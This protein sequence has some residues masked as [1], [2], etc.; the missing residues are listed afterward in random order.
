VSRKIGIEQCKK[1]AMVKG[2]RCLSTEYV[3]IFAKLCWQCEKGHEWCASLASIKYHWCPTCARERVDIAR[4]EKGIE[5]CKQYAVERGG[6]CLSP[7][8]VDIKKKLRW[9][10]AEGH[11]WVADFDHVKRGHWC[12]I[13]AKERHRL[14]CVSERSGIEQCKEYAITKGGAC[15]SVEYLNGHTKLRWQCA[16]GHEWDAPWNS[17]QRGHWCNYCN[18][19]LMEGMCR[20]IFETIYGRHFPKSRPFKRPE[21]LLELD[22][23][24]KELNLAFEYDGYQHRTG[25]IFGCQEIDSSIFERDRQKNI[26]CEERGI[27]LIRISDIETTRESVVDVIMRKLREKNISFP[28]PTEEILS[29]LRTPTDAVYRCVYDPRYLDRLREACEKHID[30]TTGYR[31]RLVDAGWAGKTHTYEIVCEK[32]HH[33]KA[34]PDGIMSKRGRWCPTCGRERIIAANEP[35]KVGIERCKQYA[36]DK[37][38]ACLSTDYVNCRTKLHWR[39]MNGHEWYAV[40]TCVQSG[41]WCQ[42]CYDERRG[43]S[44]KKRLSPMQRPEC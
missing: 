6:L 9:Q 25:K 15:L 1:L 30:P 16:N 18:I 38:G 26:Q 2:G 35:K 10:C 8:Y 43:K 34:R 31:G 17:V 22:G 12:P 36:V 21:S 4:R 23:Y 44:G 14:R 39:C 28:L 32:G 42:K 13:C 24:C 29:K 27:R 3:D 37:G 20:V 40:W 5:P 41:H 7:D 33:F 11:G 19:Y